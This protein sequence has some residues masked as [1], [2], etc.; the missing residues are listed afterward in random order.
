MFELLRRILPDPNERKVRARMPLVDRI[1]DLEAEIE[2]LSDEGLRGKTLEFRRM[3]DQRECSDNPKRD[4]QLEKEVL[5]LLLPEAFAVAREAG[6]RVLGMRHFDVQLIGG[7]V[8]H[9]G[10]ISEMRTGE[11]K[12]L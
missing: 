1:N 5:D 12:T 6:R 2:R 10:G 8:L 4:R 9:D 7:M 11:G 3:L